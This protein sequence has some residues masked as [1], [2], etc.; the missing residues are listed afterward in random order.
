MPR[1]SKLH[2]LLRDSVYDAINDN[3]QQAREAK[4]KQG[5]Y[6]TTKD[7]QL[8]IQA[9]NKQLFEALDNEEAFEIR[10]N[11]IDTLCPLVFSSFSRVI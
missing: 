11:N 3:E 9:S 7:L 4:D 10:G 2:E 1:I 8:Q 5:R 6:Y